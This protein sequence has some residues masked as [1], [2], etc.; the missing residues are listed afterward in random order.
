MLLGKASAT[1]VIAGSGFSKFNSLG[2]ACFADGAVDN[3]GVRAVGR[4]GRVLQT[5]DLSARVL[6]SSANP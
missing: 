1:L 2:L 5:C 3:G 6:K 4:S